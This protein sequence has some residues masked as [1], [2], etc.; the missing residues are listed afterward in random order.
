MA[1]K[2]EKV[3]LGLPAYITFAAFLVCIVVMI[4]LLVPSKEKRI[5]NLFKGTYTEK[6]E[7]QGQ[8]DQTKSF[9]LGDDH[10]VKMVSFSTLKKNIKKEQNTYIMY[11]DT[12]TTSFKM[13]V[14]AM[15]ELGKELE[16][17]KLYVVNSKSLSDK[18]KEYLKDKLKKVDS[19]VISIERLP[20]MDMWVTYGDEIKEAYSN[21]DF[22]VIDSEKRLSMVAK[23]HIYGYKN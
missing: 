21:P 6:A 2:Y 3:K 17:K 11:G 9:D 7:Q 18:Q 5:R 4:F 13:N 20:Q 22:D 19:D 23:Y 15:N 14:C 16:I 12:S 8:E 10:I 1:K